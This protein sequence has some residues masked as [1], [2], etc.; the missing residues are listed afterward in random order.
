MHMTARAPNPTAICT[1][2]GAIFVSMELSHSKWL[3][4]SMSPG[5][6]EKMSKHSMPAGDVAGLFALLEK[7]HE[8]SRV[9][10]AVGFQASAAE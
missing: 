9:S 8:R 10:T 1:D 2:L 6:G 5:N 7:L 3:I 4:T